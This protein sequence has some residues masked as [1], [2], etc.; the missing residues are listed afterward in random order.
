VVLTK[1]FNGVTVEIEIEKIAAQEARL[2]LRLMAKPAH[3]GIRA[4]LLK[5]EREFCSHPL[6]LDSWVS[7]Q[8]PFGRYRLVLIS[9]GQQLGSYSFEIKETIDGG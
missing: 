3:T 5:A 6:P 2:R 7:E 4:N 8:I 1:S 9:N